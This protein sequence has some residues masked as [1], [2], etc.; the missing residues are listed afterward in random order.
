[1]GLHSYIIGWVV[2]DLV[3]WN[4]EGLGGSGSDICVL[5]ACGLVSAAFLLL[6]MLVN[7][8]CGF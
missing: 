7:G 4:V 5:H 6:Q 2:D 1:M 3:Q 8:Q